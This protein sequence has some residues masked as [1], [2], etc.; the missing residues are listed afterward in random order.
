MPGKIIFKIKSSDTSIS[1]VLANTF[2]IIRLF[3][4]GLESM[5]T[6]KREINRQVIDMPAQKIDDSG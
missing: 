2:V 5:K 4:D 3:K 6:F 1:R